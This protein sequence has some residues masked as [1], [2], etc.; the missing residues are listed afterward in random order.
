METKMTIRK[1]FAKTVKIYKSHRLANGLIS[2]TYANILSANT[3]STER[4]EC[5]LNVGGALKS[6]FFHYHGF[7]G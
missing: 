6:L 7:L 3:I 1:D 5:V 4:T 2:V